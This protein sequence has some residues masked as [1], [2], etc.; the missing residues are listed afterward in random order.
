MKKKI[1]LLLLLTILLV[2]PFAS[3]SIFDWINSVITGRATEEAASTIVNEQIKCVFLNSNAEQKCYTNDGKFS[4]SGTGSCLVDVSGEKGTKLE[5]K[6]SCSGYPAY[7]TTDG[8][9]EDANFKCEIP[10]ASI[11]SNGVCES[12]ETCSS[13]P[14]DCGQCTTPEVKE[15]VKCTF[16]NSNAE[17]KCYTSDG[18][19]SCSGIGSCA[20][21]VSGQQ[22][23]QLH[24]KNSC[25]SEAYTKID[26]VDDSMEFNCEPIAIPA[27]TSTEIIAVPAGAVYEEVTCDFAYSNAIQQCYSED[28]KFSCSGKDRCL[29]KIYGKKGERIIFKGTCKEGY[30]EILIDGVYNNVWFNCEQ[31]QTQ[32]ATP[33]PTPIPAETLKDSIKNIETPAESVKEQVKC[34]FKDSNCQQK[35]NSGDS[36]FSC[37]GIGNCIVDVSGQKGAQV[38]W[39]SSCG[40]YD[41]TALD[42]NSEDAEFDCGPGSAS[43]C[44]KDK[45]KLHYFYWE[46]ECPLCESEKSFLENLKLKYPQVEYDTYSIDNPPGGK[47][48]YSYF[49]VSNLK[50]GMPTIFFDDKIWVGYNDNI[51]AEIESKVKYCLEKGCSL[52]P[53]QATQT[54][55][56]PLVAAQERVALPTVPASN[57]AKEQVECIFWNSNV[58]QNPHTARPEECYGNRFG[59]KWTGEVVEKDV[60]GNKIR[61]AHCIAEVSGEN[62]MQLVWKS[63]CGGY[64]YTTIDG[65]N[66]AAEFKCTPSAEV[67]EEQISGKGFMRAYWQ[68]YD[69]AEQK[70]VV[71]VDASCKSSDV[72]QKEAEEF[73]KGHCYSDGSKCGVN[74]FSVM[75]ECYIEAG[76]EG[77]IFAAPEK[78]KGGKK[79]AMPP[80]SKIGDIT[81]V[82]FYSDACRHCSGM[83][84]ELDKVSKELNIDIKRVNV[85]NE[86]GL[87]ESYGIKGV[88][89]ILILKYGAD[90][91]KE[92]LRHGRAD[93]TAIINWITKPEE[94]QEE[95]AEIEKLKE[96]ILICKDSCPSDGKCYPF[97]YRKGGKFCTDEGA[98]KEQLKADAVCDNNFECSTN[99]CVDGKC[100]S[101]GLIQKI[102][103]WFKK[104]FVVFGGEEAKEDAIEIVD[105]GTSTECLENA[106]KVCKPAKMSQSQGGPISEIVIVGL[107]GKKCVLKMTGSTEM[108]GGAESMTCKFEDYAL[109]MKNVGPESIEQYCTGTLTYWL[110]AAPKMIRA[111]EAPASAPETKPQQTKQEN[112]QE[113]ISTTL[114]QQQTPAPNVPTTPRSSELSKEQV[115]CKFIDPDSVQRCYADFG[116]LGCSNIIRKCYTADEKFGCS[117]TGGITSKPEGEGFRYTPDCIAE[118]YGN[119][120]TKL[121]WKGSCGESSYTV[122]DRNNENAT[123]MCVPLGSKIKGFLHASWK[124]ENGV[125]EKSIEGVDLTTCKSSDIWKEYAKESC[126]NQGGLKDYS[127]SDE[128]SMVAEKEGIFIST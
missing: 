3:A 73:C 112:V 57:I 93:S 19:F 71:S 24:W 117:W 22:G 51:A 10:A 69:G 8:I 102:T 30:S 81:V 120:G 85:I 46:K 104:L 33:T 27:P 18:K 61:Y 2:V 45:V 23:Q 77:V 108:T 94:V 95:P 126:K 31:A 118:V 96:E 26:G 84:E 89:A 15:Q 101:S 36:K 109:G 37:S 68:C 39:G 55:P 111:G 75:D 35:C 58:L 56:I 107:E 42:G 119:L 16:L 1:I 64:A 53:A 98:F 105:C 11:C 21:Y 43:T 34:V 88:P 48:S 25:G 66:E 121:T 47:G 124:C 6:S 4:C 128:C 92:Y 62:G 67:K 116:K 38:T 29:A 54:Y 70:Q 91:I 59:C 127:V 97:G 65:N 113:P 114:P 50:Q 115:R 63:S 5:W 76:K 80:D 82:Y 123:F 122:I 52:I 7:T 79:F 125:E 99:V 14:A 17:Q 103:N 44:I 87:V 110:A 32:I 100:I 86:P 13:C 20:I 60:N 78:P 40:G 74:S 41:Y 9:N 90:G 72:W 106:F 83:N 12:G 28:K 49:V